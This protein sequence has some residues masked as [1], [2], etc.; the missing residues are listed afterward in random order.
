MD[1]RYKG[2]EVY[3]Y[4]DKLVDEVTRTGY[5]GSDNPSAK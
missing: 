4:Q 2:P 5:Y 3:A 1:D